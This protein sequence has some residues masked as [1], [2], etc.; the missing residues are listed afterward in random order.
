MGLRGPDGDVHVGLRQGD[1]DERTGGLEINGS[2]AQIS[3]ASLAEFLENRETA[4]GTVQEGKF[5]FRGS[6]YDLTRATLSTRFEATDF[7][8]GKRRWNSLVVGATMVDRRIQIPEFKLVQAHNELNA[9]GESTLPNPGVRWWQSD[10]SFDIAARINK[11]VWIEELID[12]AENEA[13][14]QLYGLLKRPD[15]KFVTER[16]YDNP[17]FVEDLVRDIA[18][19]LKRDPRIGRFWI[20]SEN[21]ES[22]HN[23][24]AYAEIAGV[25][26]ALRDVTS[27]DGLAGC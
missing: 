1:R 4:G 27:H 22:I 15:E 21:F 13:S 23:H 20:A 14:C 25:G 11:F 6:P 26:A 8:W 5:T 3:V 2:F 7:S 24:S 16:A 17:K 10:F 12:V 19:R 18:L 9:K